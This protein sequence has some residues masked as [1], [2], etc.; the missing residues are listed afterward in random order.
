MLVCVVCAVDDSEEED[1]EE[2]ESPIKRNR[3]GSGA[4]KVCEQRGAL[5]LWVEVFQLAS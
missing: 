3:D 4:S 1:D 5:S 2:F